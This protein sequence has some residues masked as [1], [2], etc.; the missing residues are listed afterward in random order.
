LTGDYAD[1]KAGRLWG[2]CEW[3]TGACIQRNQL[4]W[5]SEES[6]R[7][8]VMT[9]FRS[10]KNNACKK[11]LNVLEAGYLTQVYKSGSNENYSS[12]VWI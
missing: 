11:V 6:I 3:L 5:A 10:F 4:F 8:E 2:L 12:Q 7:Q 1:M 9:G